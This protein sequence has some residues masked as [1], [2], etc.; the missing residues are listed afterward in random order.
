MCI[1]IYLELQGVFAYR[2]G[3]SGNGTPDVRIFIERDIYRIVTPPMVVLAFASC[4]SI[5]GCDDL[6]LTSRVWQTKYI[7]EIH[8]KSNENSCTR[9]TIRFN[10]NIHFS[11]WQRKK[12]HEF[13]TVDKEWCILLFFKREFRTLCLLKIHAYMSHSCSGFHY[14]NWFL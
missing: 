10:K 9:H 11:N 14:K 4:L 12:L 3:S 2:R 8:M 6:F 13:F 5:C 1:E 7:P